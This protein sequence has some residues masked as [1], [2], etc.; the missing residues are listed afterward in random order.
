M[1]SDEVYLYKIPPM[2]NAGGHRA[3]D[4]NLAEPLKACT[5][6]VER[7]ED[8]LVLEF[9]AD[10]GVFAQSTLDTT[11]GGKVAQFLEQCV[12]TSRYFVVKIQGAGGREAMIGFG[13]RD[14]EKATDLRESLQHYEKSIQREAE[15]H[16]TVGNFHIPQLAEGEKIHV[17]GKTGK[18][19]VVKSKEKKVGIPLLSKKPP[20]PSEEDSTPKKIEKVSLT[21]EGIDLNAPSGD[22][23]SDTGSGGAVFEGDEAEWKTEFDMK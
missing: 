19:K 3:E 8:T 5:L 7:R 1:T 10:G 18:T 21:M 4:W 6:L 23:G 16:E 22:A 15:A 20:P 11:K 13:F 9:Q 14:R 12:D 2:K 17:G